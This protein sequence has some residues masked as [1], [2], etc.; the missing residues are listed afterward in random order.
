MGI[1]WTVVLTAMGVLPAAGAAL[2]ASRIVY[3]STFLTWQRGLQM[4]GFSVMH[5]SVG[6]IGLLALLLAMLWAIVVAVVAAYRRAWPSRGQI[7]LIV[8]V[9]LSFGLLRIP[10]GYWKLLTVKICGVERVTPGWLTYAAAKGEKRLLQH[11][12][13]NGFDINTRNG[14]GDSLLTIAKRT[15][16]TS[17][18]EWL[19]AHG[20]RE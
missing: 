16:H 6:M 19:I 14:G 12:I 3:E 20:A 11:L 15:G 10:Y 2:L 8:I 1:N 13:A 18:S 17:L 4:V 7:L 5:S 9:A